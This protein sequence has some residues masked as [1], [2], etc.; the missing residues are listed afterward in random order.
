LV[1]DDEPDMRYLLR[2]IFERAGHEVVDAGDGAAALALVSVSP[3]DLVVTDMMMPVMGGV[4]LI[5]HLRGNPV[6]AQIPILAATG[7]HQVATGADAVVTKPYTPDQL[8]TAAYQL[9]AQKVN[10][11]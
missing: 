9:F 10:R 5:R 3:P 7:D 1:V 8:L 4:D 6:T 11:P 2:T